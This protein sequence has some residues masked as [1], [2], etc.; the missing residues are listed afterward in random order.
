VKSDRNRLQSFSPRARRFL[1]AMSKNP[2]SPV[3]TDWDTT[4]WP[5]PS[6]PARTQETKIQ[7]PIPQSTK[8]KEQKKSKNKASMSLIKTTNQP[9]SPDDGPTLE[10]NT[11]QDNERSTTSQ[12]QTD[13]PETVTPIEVTSNQPNSPPA[14]VRRTNLKYP[15][16]DQGPFI[17]C[18]ES[19]SAADNIKQ[20]HPSILQHAFQKVLKPTDI[21]NNSGSKLSAEFTSRDDANNFVD[22]VN[23]SFPK[24]TAFIPP[25]FV[26]IT[27][28]IRG[29][30]TSVPADEILQYMTCKSDPSIKITSVKRCFRRDNKD[31]PTES[32][33]ISFNS[34]VLPDIVSLYNY[35]WNVDPFVRKLSQ[36]TNC[37]RFKHIASSC[38]AH[39]RCVYCG[40]KLSSHVNSDPESC[41]T[42]SSPCCLNCHGTHPASHSNIC[43]SF[44]HVSNSYAHNPNPGLNSRLGLLQQQQQ[45]RNAPSVSFPNLNCTVSFPPLTTD[46]THQDFSSEETVEP[47][48]VTHEDV[49]TR[50]SEDNNITR[51][52]T[53]TKKPPA[54][55]LQDIIASQ[56]PSTSTCPEQPYQPAPTHPP[57]SY[58][59]THSTPSSSENRNIP[60]S[61]PFQQLIIS[62]ADLIL[63][64]INHSFPYFFPMASSF[65]SAIL[66]SMFQS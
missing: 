62:I 32:V 65:V 43:P 19:K 23:N 4:P 61:Q 2:Q 37:W 45:S 24:L 52:T 8:F 6:K 5:P 35:C 39:A 42:K 21:I 14:F 57:H 54:F 41:P 63:Q 20:I 29:V 33:I 50:S 22:F 25:S 27:G 3:T 44:I 30:P 17:V 66:N 51:R 18:L 15:T 48:I 36:C 56:R 64:F 55:F 38:R 46:P 7:F 53:Q 31:I 26:E 9:P 16:N 12:M 11:P 1:T 59:P 40:D 49:H 13:P 28:V 47:T 58:H 60:N 10:V 34:K